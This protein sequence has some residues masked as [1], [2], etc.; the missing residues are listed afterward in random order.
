MNMSLRLERP[1]D[2]VRSAT[3]IVEPWRFDLPE[4]KVEATGHVVPHRAY[5]TTAEL[6]AAYSPHQLRWKL[7]P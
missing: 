5:R 4:L 7:A 1:A 6:L 2:P 3:V